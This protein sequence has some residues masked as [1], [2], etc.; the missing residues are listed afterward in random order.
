MGT[1]Q[2]WLVSEEC[3]LWHDNCI[4]AF[5]DASMLPFTHLCHSSIGIQSTVCWHG[6]NG[7]TQIYPQ[8]IQIGWKKDE[9]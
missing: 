9:S 1:R 2:E 8:S 5:N 3:V 4:S 6:N 7:Y